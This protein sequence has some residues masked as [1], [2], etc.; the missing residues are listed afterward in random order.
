ME[1]V[2]QNKK[3]HICAGE[4]EAPALRQMPHMPVA[5][6]GMACRFPGGCDTPEKFWSLL[7]DGRNGIVDVPA[8]RWADMDD[9]CHDDTIENA[10]GIGK[11]GFLQND[12]RAFDPGFFWISP[13]E[14]AEMDP[15]Q[16]LL[17]EVS[18]EALERSGQQPGHLRGSR[19]GVYMGII[20][21][22]YSWH[23]RDNG[24][25][26]QYAIT[27]NALGIA[28]GRIS[29][30]FGLH[31]PSL[32]VD[33]ACSSSLVSVHL[34]CEALRSGACDMA[35]AGGVNLM[36]SP[37]PS[38]VLGKMGALAKD[39]RCKTF[40]ADADGYVRSEGCGI[41]VLKRL[42]DAERDD[43]IILATILGS[44]VNHN[45]GG[46]GLTV[47]TGKS[48]QALLREALRNA[49]VNASDVDFLEAH[50]TGTA[51]GDPIEMQAINTIFGQSRARKR[52]LYIGA[53]K[54]NIGHLEAAAGIAGLMKTILCLEKTAIPPNL[55]LRRQNPKIDA[56]RV[57]LVFPGRL[58]AWEDIGKPRIA[59]VSAF[60][61]SGTNAHMILQASSGKIPLGSDP[62]RPLHLLTVSA[63]SHKALIELADAY[64]EFMSD[65][66]ALRVQD[67]CHTANVY[68]AQFDHRAAFIGQDTDEM[69][70][71]LNAYLQE[72][73]KEG[74]T[75]PDRRAG[76]AI[77]IA[78]VYSENNGAENGGWVQNR[79]LDLFRS[80]PFFKECMEA[81]D[82]LYK[83]HLNGSLLDFLYAPDTRIPAE[84]AKLY[85]SAAIFSL[86]YSASMLLGRW[87]IR[88][89]ATLGE[90]TGICV[91]ACVA[92]ILPLDAAVALAVETASLP[93]R[94]PGGF[95]HTLKMTELDGIDKMRP[96][97][98]CYILSHTGLRLEI[99][100]ADPESPVDSASRKLF[101]EQ[102]RAPAALDAGI[103]GLINAGYENLLTFGQH[104][105]SLESLSNRNSSNG[106]GVRCAVDD[107]FRWRNILTI[108]SQLYCAGASVDWAAFDAGYPRR[109]VVLPTY[110]F[111]RK[112]Y[113]MPKSSR[114]AV[115]RGRADCA[116]GIPTN[117]GYAKAAPCNALDGRVISSPLKSTILEYILSAEQLPE[118]ADN[119]HVLHVGYY[120][121]MLMDAMRKVFGAN[122]YV[123]RNIRYMLLLLVPEETTK[124]VQLV[125]E[126]GRNNE[127]EFQFYSRDPSK[128]TWE[129][130]ADGSILII[131]EEKGKQRGF[132]APAD[133]KNRCRSRYSHD[134][135]YEMMKKRGYR[136]GDSVKVIDDVWFSEGEAL[137]RIKHVNPALMARTYK[138][139]MHPG[140]LDACAQLYAP[141]FASC[142]EADSMFMMVRW[143]YFEFTTLAKGD[144]LTDE[145][146]LWAH[147]KLSERDRHGMIKGAF[148]LLD[149]GGNRIAACR[150]AWMVELTDERLG[151]FA[152]AL[153]TEKADSVKED[154]NAALEP[155]FQDRANRD[156]LDKLGR[157]DRPDRQACMAQYLAGQLSAILNIPENEMDV[158]TPFQTYGMDSLVGIEFSRKL[159]GELGISV[160]F[161]LII[162]SETVDVLA[163]NILDAL[164]LNASTGQDGGM[165]VH[166][167]TEN[168]KSN[169]KE[170]IRRIKAD[171]VLPPDIRISESVLDFDPSK[172]LM[173]ILL[174]GATGYLGV[175][176]LQQLLDKT[177]ADIHCLVRAASVDAGRRRIQ[178]RM[179]AYQL[180]NPAFA[181]RIV[182]V[183]GDI[184]AEKLGLDADT[185]GRLTHCVD[186]IYHTAADTNHTASY[187]QLK[188]VD[189]F[190]TLAL[191]RM[192]AQVKIK[193]VFFV[194]T[195]GVPI[196][197]H[198]DRLEFIHRES[199]IDDISGFSFILG[200]WGGK[201]VSEQ[202]LDQAMKLGIPMMIFRVGE[203][204]GQSHTGIGRTDDM[205]VTLF[206]LFYSVDVKTRWD[207]AIIDM[208]PV[209]YISRAIVY[210]SSIKKHMGEVFFLTNPAPAGFDILFEVVEEMKRKRMETLDFEEWVSSCRD[211]IAAVNDSEMAEV[212]RE[213]FT[214]GVSFGGL[215]YRFMF[216]FQN[217]KIS[218][219]KVT[220]ALDGS[221]I[222][223]PP[224]DKALLRRYFDYFVRAGFFQS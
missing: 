194:S 133:I 14:A 123:V 201:W 164:D 140:V 15:Q 213:Y 207:N 128:Q 117:A 135:F 82:T 221:G 169:M 217:F 49:G 79:G 20:G 69:V 152:Q 132:E 99:L 215:K 204:T 145:D 66:G 120:Q 85:R 113:W 44:A 177:D 56:D 19:T 41:I 206:K 124:K 103:S 5:V 33:T 161:Q 17:L 92:G 166:T 109:K 212:L 203:M 62:D 50:G 186:A 190:S 53:V 144:A 65:A 101:T 10:A 67:V 223:C 148:Q 93:G 131:Q 137:A 23:A 111:Q 211:N 178:R 127:I 21:N 39:G 146:N 129:L 81:C 149:G 36:L 182:P 86:Y 122:R 154:A 115:N 94:R 37:W 100:G 22:E 34:A 176:V 88:P 2:L 187:E 80:Q 6:I 147:V 13:R 48:Q 7:E 208:V 139:G 25:T 12:I 189:G 73:R 141:A 89:A 75:V 118:V 98:I 219:T 26:G 11:G 181:S 222:E 172:S 125:M 18:W 210:L 29:H 205:F 52:P 28:S 168:M 55:H 160:N 130:H 216:Y 106:Q 184:A 200:Y 16:R 163:K 54:T 150:E 68:K 188:H 116:T 195:F 179:A 78:F 151:A 126:A 8:N 91:A 105:A 110:P 51:L 104:D 57:P 198:E 180:W 171:A 9:Y 74:K 162:S 63:G 114:M 45:G 97:E 167:F 173:N 192:A 199:V 30:V 196:R 158:K 119:H 77:K 107:D 38:I 183:P 71:C 218:N 1:K 43:D 102:F 157:L 70:S 202:L 72:N 95:A 191:I 84:K 35:L 61:F 83:V 159:S 87:G 134:A 153:D 155:S 170:T 175:F 31:G 143:E 96:P 46:S 121:E 214:E 220:K 185:Y 58:A 90:K 138:I 165:A 47:P 3:D 76:R 224:V 142:V 108:V 193:P 174:T 156:F 27:G 64:M 4:K 60:G 112:R 24:L 59:G 42:R 32:A 40:D 197:I 209:D 136:L